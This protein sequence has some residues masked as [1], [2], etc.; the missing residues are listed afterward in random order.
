ML[1]QKGRVGRAGS[2]VCISCGGVLGQ[3]PRGVEPSFEDEQS[4]WQPMTV[5]ILIKKVL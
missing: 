1:G 4:V 2:G 5:K 3:L